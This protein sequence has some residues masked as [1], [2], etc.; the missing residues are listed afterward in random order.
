MNQDLLHNMSII[1]QLGTFR[2]V[3][4]LNGEL[5][6]KELL[7]KVNLP[8]IAVDGAS[9]ILH[10]IDVQPQL[11]I[12]DLDSDDQDIL[13]NVER[14]YTPDQ[15]YTDFQKTIAYLNENDLLP[16]VVCG[17]SGGYIDHILHNISVFSQTNS[18]FITDHQIGFML[19]K[20][21]TFKLPINSK[22]SII[23]CPGAIIN[24]QGL[25]WELENY[26]IDMFNFNSLS[27]RTVKEKI[28][29]DI[30]CGKVLVIVY[31]SHIIDAGSISGKVSY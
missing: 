24:S 11:I 9:K 14:I 12:G 30:I 21:L 31:M 22:I 26:Q 28:K 20:N 3:I 5:P 10:Q 19:D 18:I 4:C 23:G 25:K 13:P 7:E 2:S 1:S 29:L 16:G 17:V 8:I 6:T 27:N 15:D